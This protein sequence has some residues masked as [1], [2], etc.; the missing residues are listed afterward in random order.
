MAKSHLYHGFRFAGILDSIQLQRKLQA[1]MLEYLR[2]VRLFVVGC[3]Y[4]DELAELLSEIDR[5][6]TDLTI[7]TID[8]AAVEDTLRSHEFA[9]LL[10]PRLQWMQRNLM[11]ASDIPGYGQFDVV[12]CSFVLHDVDYQQK[13][14]AMRMLSR[15][16]RPGGHLIVSDI[17][18]SGTVEDRSEIRSIYDAFLS[19]ADDAC[20]TG[21]LQN[22]EWRLLV[23]DGLIP[24]L[25]RARNEAIQ[26]IRDFFETPARLIG[27][28]T[29]AGLRVCQVEPNPLNR[30]LRVMLMR[31]PTNGYTSFPT[32][33]GTNVL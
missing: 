5:Q 31:R 7:T 25:L 13:D 1:K 11:D 19:E 24:G 26:G 6:A 18:L 9:M 30:R 15:A 12:Q 16:V 23:G 28:A 33:G 3:A 14:Q 4:G 10:G 21:Q 2:P 32:P 20:R 27:R 17:F 8:L 22:Y 29:R